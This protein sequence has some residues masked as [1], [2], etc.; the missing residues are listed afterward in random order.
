MLI[1][2]NTFIRGWIHAFGPSWTHSTQSAIMCPKT[3]AP[4]FAVKSHSLS[5]CLDTADCCLVEDINHT[6]L[7][8]RVF[9]RP[10]SWATVSVNSG[11][12]RG[13]DRSESALRQCQRRVS[14]RANALAPSQQPGA[15]PDGKTEATIEKRRLQ[16]GGL[17]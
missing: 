12:Q 17:A 8:G 10:E 3:S 4:V 6:R 16:Q 7:A 9:N 2:I 13:Q 11:R 15:D 5:R 14:Q 1:H